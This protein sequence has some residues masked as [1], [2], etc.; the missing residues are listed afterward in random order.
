[1]KESGRERVDDRNGREIRKMRYEEKEGKRDKESNM[2]R[3][4]MKKEEWE[5]K[6]M[7]SR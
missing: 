4:W 1:M 5:W 7:G 3:E 6:T 2:R